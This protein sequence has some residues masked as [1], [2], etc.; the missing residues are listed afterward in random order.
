MAPPRDRPS[1]P[2]LLLLVLGYGALVLWLSWPLPR[3]AATHVPGTKLTCDF[4]TRHMAW[5]L[6]WQ[7]H[8][9]LT[10]PASLP[11]AN[12]YHPAQWALF[13]TEAGV[14][15]VPYV[16]PTWAATGNAALALNG[17]LLLSL[18]LTACTLHLVARAWTGL[19]AAGLVAAT[20]F[21][22]TGWLLWGWI[23]TAPHY[24]ILQYL[25]LIV[26]LA[27]GRA[28]GRVRAAALT[29]LLALQALVSPYLALAVMA[30][31]GVL[32]VVRLP[33]SATR[34][35]GLALLGC[36]AVASCLIAPWY[37]GYAVVVA[38]DPTVLG[39]TPWSAPG[40]DIVDLPWGLI[41]ERSPLGLPGPSLLLIVVGVVARLG[42]RL[43]QDI[44]PPI[45]WAPA[46]YWTVAGALL[47]LPNHGVIGDQVIQLPRLWLAHAMPGS[48]VVRFGQRL[49]VIGTI[50]LALLVGVAFGECVR[51]VG[52]VWRGGRPAPA[53]VWAA[54]VLV[55][56]AAYGSYATGIGLSK[57]RA[58]PLPR[59][60][61]LLAVTPPDDVT[62]TSL[63][64]AAG[65]VLELPADVP[66]RL[67]R[68]LGLHASAM[69]RST[70]H[71]RPLLNGYTSYQPAGQAQRMAWADRLPG[72]GAL[73]HL[74]R[75]T[76]LRHVV[77]RLAYLPPAQQARWLEIA[78][79]TDDPIWRSLPASPREL[80]FEIRDDPAAGSR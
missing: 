2:S 19:A 14:G 15:A 26:L 67:G 23:A 55:S 52:A 78:E 6:A 54:A 73:A 53:L 45:P 39:R 36:L 79:R 77:V 60:Y 25:P 76:G 74:R 70:F 63:R 11:H 57:T 9:L 16:L 61:A 31:L 7:S 59:R 34:P 80:V 41:G 37:A 66:N 32:A 44:A 10:N 47:M 30:P 40:A 58:T 46:V 69:Y 38:A 75:T 49:G 3:H 43:R 50:G 12:I 51:A 35:R 22:C 48:E 18:A 68:T 4:D 17:M 29:V 24:A 56:L 28:L 33:R 65:A 64:R 71:W 72:P 20:A 62:A 42:R 13:H 8:A 1:L 5:V 27:T 21:L